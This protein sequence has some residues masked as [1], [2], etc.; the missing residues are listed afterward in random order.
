[1][2]QLDPLSET[3][4]D[5]IDEI[6]KEHEDEVTEV[7]DNSFS[8]LGTL[9]NFGLMISI[10]IVLIISIFF[11]YLFN[12][13]KII[14]QVAS[15]ISKYGAL[16]FQDSI[17]KNLLIGGEVGSII[18][19][20]NYMVNEIRKFLTKT[21]SLNNEITSDSNELLKFVS[22]VSK[23]SHE[24]IN[25]TKNL[26]S[27]IDKVQ[28]I[29]E[30]ERLSS[31]ETQKNTT[32]TSKILTDLSTTMGIINRRI[33]INSNQQQ[34]LSDELKNLNYNVKKVM[35]VLDKI[36][37]I[38]DQTGLLALNAA[39]EASKAGSF[40]LGFGVVSEEIKKLAETTD[41]IIISINSEMKSFLD[42]INTISWKMVNNS[43]D[44][45]EIKTITAEI[46]MKTNVANSKMTTTASDTLKT[47]NNIQDMS[48]KNKHVI[49]NSES[50]SKL[51]SSNN[52]TIENI[53]DFTNE[54]SKKLAIQNSEL[55]KFQL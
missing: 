18:T 22:D 12:I 9:Q 21:G 3:L 25:I 39:I 50:I 35:N 7:V 33:D 8:Q 26:S 54:L 40:G 4:Q 48:D 44:I 51:S 53:V 36:G 27:E 20:V 41:N 13:S 47:F 37:E 45:V 2:K 19:N 42:A 52:L 16:N 34:L 30:L 5:T 49:I 23:R 38:A 46:N 31:T 17:D 11:N 32:D 55:R 28:Y 10:I 43:K 6:V 14:D 15:Y 29:M 1:M 24:Q